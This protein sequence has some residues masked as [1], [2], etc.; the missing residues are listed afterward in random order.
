MPIYFPQ[1]RATL[2]VVFDGFGGSDTEPNIVQVLPINANVRLNGYKEADTWQLEF[3]AREFPF[4]PELI[5]NAAVEIFMFET[6]GLQDSPAGYATDDN[7][8][9]AGLA[10]NAFLD[11]TG[12]GH[13]FRMDGRDYTALFLDKQWI[14]TSKVPT[15]VSLDQAIAKLAGEAQVAK[16]ID[17]DT[18]KERIYKPHRPI[19]VRYIGASAPP[20]VGQRQAKDRTLTQKKVKGQKAAAPTSGHG[21]SASSKNGIPF[22]SGQSYWDVMYKLCLRHGKIC[23]VRGVEIIISDPKTLSDA[24]LETVPKMAF[25]RNLDSLS[26][27]RHLGRETVPTIVVTGYDENNR[28]PIEVKY[29]PK[30]GKQTGFGTFKDEERRYVLMGITDPTILRNYARTLYHNLARHELKMHFTTG[31]LRDLPDDPNHGGFGPNSLLQL[32]PGDAVGV[33]FDPFND[34]QMRSLKTFQL[35]KQRLVEL[36]YKQDVA[37]IVAEGYD[38]INQF[39]QPWYVRQVVLDWQDEEDGGLTIDCEG[40]NF[41]SQGR[42]DKET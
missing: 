36:G 23:F 24:A 15:G 14:P 11:Y 10:D 34:E 42:D 39:K 4:S 31:D 40:V 16:V 12:D 33:G 18:G 25:G 26:V 30:K 35:R 20:V 8:V 7:L 29:G 1:V 28:K 2:S 17:P 9:V 21:H 38:K 3:D 37:A 27:E 22:K 41:V 19:T 5:R 6:N 32:R 13:T